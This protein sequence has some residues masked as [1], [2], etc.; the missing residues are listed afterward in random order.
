MTKKEQLSELIKN[1]GGYLASFDAQK[2]GISRAYLH[3]YIKANK[4]E[5]VSHGLYKSHDAWMDDLYIL[6]LKNEKAV[7]SFETA[8]MLH[9]LTEREPTE[10]FVT[11]PRSYNASHLRNNGITVYQAKEEW[12]ALGRTVAKTVYGNEVCV[13]DK[14]RAICDIVRVKGKKDPQMFAYALKEYIKR[15]DKNLPL[16]IKYAKIFGIEAELRR[17][18][19]VMI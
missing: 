3:E 6:S 19:E 7:F 18:I 2:L 16:L 12:W 10:I 11:V 1:Q 15:T 9:G 13:Y 5:K 4:F 14:E 17:Y 8:L